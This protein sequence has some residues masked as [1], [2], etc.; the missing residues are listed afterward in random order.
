VS[1]QL[2]KR[3]LE[4]LQNPGSWDDSKLE[5]VE[6][7]KKPRAV[8]SVAFQR[9]EFELVA[10][11]ARREGVSTSGFIR[12]AAVRRA[13]ASARLVSIQFN[14]GTADTGTFFIQMDPTP[15][16]QVASSVHS[17]SRQASTA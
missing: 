11:Q 16:T 9:H 8:V 17:E 14:G 7:S 15:R 4:E 6:P 5:V 12:V 10:G 1:R 2:E 13:R 3:D